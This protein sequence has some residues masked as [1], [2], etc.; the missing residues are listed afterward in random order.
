M[1]LYYP[2]ALVTLLSGLLLFAM[3]LT[4][5]RTRANVG[6]PAPAMT[7]DPL[8][9]RTIRAHY[10]TLEWILIFLPALWMFAIYVS[11]A[12]AAG[13]G[14]LWIVARI[15][16]FVGYRAEAKKRFPGFLVQAGTTTVLLLG[17][18]AGVV[19]FWATPGA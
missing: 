19:Y 13:L 15:V 5:A 6:I 4:V 1:Q 7:G 14:A 8:L 3:A 18:L 17:A 16:Y 2:V 9:E 12:W 10:N 11:V